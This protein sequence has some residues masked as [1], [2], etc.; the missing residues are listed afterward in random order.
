M[1]MKLTP[2]INFTNILHAHFSYK[3]LVPKITKVKQNKKADRF[4][5]VIFGAKILAEKAR[6][7]R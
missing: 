7:K 6:V 5:F 1:L 3:I 2:V 4:S